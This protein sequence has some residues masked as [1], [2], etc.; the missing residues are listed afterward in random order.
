MWALAEGFC[1]HVLRPV[2]QQINES[3]PEMEWLLLG[4]ALAGQR[5]IDMDGES[6]GGCGI[7]ALTSQQHRDV[8]DQYLAFQPELAS[9]VRGLASQHRFLQQPDLELVTNLAYASAVAATYLQWRSPQVPSTR[10]ADAY[11][12]H[13]QTTFER[14]PHQC[15]LLRRAYAQIFRPGTISSA[16]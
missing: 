5:H 15:P 14:A 16:A 4:A 7:Y 1:Q 12:L 11:T 10:T 9:K 3:R 2:L 13:W 8:W 6:V